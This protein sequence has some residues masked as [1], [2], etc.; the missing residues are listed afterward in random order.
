[1]S[2][3]MRTYNPEFVA[4]DK[5]V[6]DRMHAQLSEVVQEFTNKPPA[7]MSTQTRTIRLRDMNAQ[8]TAL[9]TASDALAFV[10]K[11]IRLYGKDGVNEEVGARE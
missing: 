10:E 7:G 4:F 1:M 11:R 5:A 2:S 9:K 8:L 3:D 6:I